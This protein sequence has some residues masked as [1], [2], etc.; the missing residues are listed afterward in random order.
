MMEHSLNSSTVRRPTS[1]Q[2]EGVSIQPVYE[3]ALLD[4]FYNDSRQPLACSSGFDPST[5]NSLD[6]EVDDWHSDRSRNECSFR[7]RRIGDDDDNFNP[8]RINGYD[9]VSN[10]GFGDGHGGDHDSLLSRKATP[11]KAQK[12]LTWNRLNAALFV[13]QA[14]LS[15]ATSAPITLVPTMALSLAGTNDEEWDYAP[16]Y[17]LETL[18]VY[19]ESGTRKRWIPFRIRTRASNR[20]QRISASSIFASHLTSVVTLVTAFGNFING[21]LVDI[22]GA[23]RL[24]II[25]GTCTC[26][27]LIGLSYSTTQNWA[28][29][30]CAAVEFFSSINWPAGIVIL[31]AHYMHGDDSNGKFERG[32]YVMSLASRCGSFLAIPLSSLL[33]KWTYLTWRGIAVIAACAAL[34]GVAVFFFYLTDSPGKVHD[35]QNPLRA[36]QNKD[37]GS[38]HHPYHP[39]YHSWS[40]PQPSMFQRSIDF[41]TAVFHTVLPSIRAILFSRV[42]WAV[43][44]A[45]AGASMVKSSERILGTYFIDTSFGNVSESKAGA[46]TVFLSLGMLGGLLV[47]GKAF[48]K[49]ADSEQRRQIRPQDDTPDRTVPLIDAAQ[50]G[51]KN[52]IAFFYCL[53]ICMCYMLS[54]LAMPFVRRA[55]HLPAL[56][57]ILQ[58]FAT[59]GLGF[60]VAIQ[61]YHIPAI[62]GATYGKHQGLY[63]AYTSGVAAVVSSFVWRIVGGAVEEGN[64]EGGGWAYGWAA[65]ALLLVFCGTLM[66]KIIELYFVGGGWRHDT[67]IELAREQ[68]ASPSEVPDD[69]NSSWMDDEIRSTGFSVDASPLRQPGSLNVL[70]SSALEFIGSPGRIQSRRKLLSIDSRDEVDTTAAKANVDSLGI[71]DDGSL[72]LPS[73]NAG[74]LDDDFISFNSILEP[75]IDLRDNESCIRE[76]SVF[77]DPDDD[78]CSSFEL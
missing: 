58:V 5:L 39:S 13:G 2:E 41:C 50:L 7:R 14:L 65:V 69:I 38:A 64:P 44:A 4:D 40:T 52:M 37:S 71:D 62:V 78:P 22:A 6:E 34:G 76:T 70:S 3:E 61:Y 77:D 42:F 11:P 17:N 53:S 51:T 15:A 35:P 20:N 68:I 36:Q 55:L 54:F 30:C 32:I 29:G 25:Y 67:P 31:G 57:L 16:Y 49:A 66:V 48:A 74:K 19:D 73:S 24:M 56:V 21:S 60:G 72:L 59:L 9:S 18:E 33:I 1:A 46:M 23:R 8:K 63:T 10:A 75:R 27:A 47:G 12:H 43:A 26:F 45:H 28:I